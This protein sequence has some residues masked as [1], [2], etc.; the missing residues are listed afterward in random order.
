ME[1]IIGKRNST[2][3]V[4][5]EFELKH[6]SEILTPEALREFGLP[7]NTATLQ[8]IIS[9][10]INSRRNLIENIN[11]EKSSSLPAIQRKNEEILQSLLE[12]FSVLTDTVSSQLGRVYKYIPADMYH[13]SPAGNICISEKAIEI[14]ERR[15]A[16]I[17]DQESQLKAYELAEKA[18][19]A[20]KDLDTYV[21][22]Y[23]ISAINGRITALN[24]AGEVIPLAIEECKH[25]G[26]FK[27]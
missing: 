11:K 1:K 3:Q 12:S 8:D 25:N 4:R 22:Q 21:R 20:I 18:E 27:G 19:K 15:D 13:I 17:I 14:F 16:I 2:E 24:K 10:G 23:G 5:F 9:G 26:A 7:F 6:I